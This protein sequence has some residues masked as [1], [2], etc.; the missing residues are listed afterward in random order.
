MKAIKFSVG[1][2]GL[3]FIKGKI[4][5][6]YRQE[7]TMKRFRKI[8]VRFEKTGRSCLALVHL[9]CAIITWRKGGIIYG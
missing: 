8:L 2:R 7:T 4:S 1:K 3:Q 5:R 6:G 9:A